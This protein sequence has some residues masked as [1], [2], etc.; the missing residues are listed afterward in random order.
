MKEPKSIVAQR[1]VK[2][3]FKWFESQNEE[4][5]VDA[6]GADEE[7]IVIK[8]DVVEGEESLSEDEDHIDS[9]MRDHKELK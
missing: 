9:K 4:Q 8:R 7:E 1:G 3:V 5:P 6:D 2:A